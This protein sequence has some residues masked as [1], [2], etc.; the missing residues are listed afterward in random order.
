[1]APCR[2]PPTQDWLSKFKPLHGGASASIHSYGQFADQR[3]QWLCFMSMNM[4]AKNFV[5]STKQ[6][7][8]CCDLFAKPL[9]RIVVDAWTAPD[10]LHIPASLRRSAEAAGIPLPPPITRWPVLLMLLLLP[11]MLSAPSSLACTS[12]TTPW[13]GWSTEYWIR[14]MLQLPNDFVRASLSGSQ[15]AVVVLL[16]VVVPQQRRQRC[17]MWQSRAVNLLTTRAESQN[18]LYCDAHRGDLFAAAVLLTWG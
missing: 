11:L 7:F 15:H 9:E 6:Q 4:T 2:K 16:Q 13:G 5:T 10:F 3:A 1:M 14:M 12:G 18:A 8:S 17:G